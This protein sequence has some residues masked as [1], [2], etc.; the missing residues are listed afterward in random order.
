MYP[1]HTY[2]QRS[3]TY[4]PTYKQT[5][6]HTQI[7]TCILK[8]MHANKPCKHAYKPT[9]NQTNTQTNIHMQT[10]NS[11]RTANRVRTSA[12]TVA[13]T[14]VILFFFWVS[15]T[16]EKRNSTLISCTSTAYC[17]CNGIEFQCPI[18]IS[19]V[20]FQRNVVKET[21]RTRSSNQIWEW[22]N[23]TPNAIGCT[24]LRIFCDSSLDCDRSL[25][26]GSGSW[27]TCFKF[28]W[29]SDLKKTEF[30]FHF[31]NQYI[32]TFFPR[33]LMA[34]LWQEPDPQRVGM[35]PPENFLSTGWRRY[36]GCLIFIDYFLQKSPMMS[37]SF[38]ESDLQRILCI[39]ATLYDR[40]HWPKMKMLHPWERRIEKP[41]FLGTNKD[42]T[43]F[44]ISICTA[45]FW[46]IR[47]SRF[48]GCW[49]SQSSIFIGICHNCPPWRC[50][51]V[52]TVSSPKK[53]RTKEGKSLLASAYK[54]RSECL[55]KWKLHVTVL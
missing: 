29:V 35:L 15:D 3:T 26:S 53:A 12:V 40:F 16:Q 19:L 34:K 49:G 31:Q 43:K 17:I 42:W 38:V 2:M 45:R 36:V 1:V 33:L 27:N 14:Y 51:P 13:D 54:K 6:I 30:S 50:L 5:N 37:G 44:S 20:S 46:R 10:F 28:F 47:V 32:P 23:D 48:S 11:P 18:S 41:R 4:I 22:T 52:C 7:Q 24:S 9:H 21:Y 25:S 39:F 55:R 8:C